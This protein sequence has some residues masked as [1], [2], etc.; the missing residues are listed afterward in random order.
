MDF[1][2][3]SCLLLLVSLGW[4]VGGGFG[5]SSASAS[6]GDYVQIGSGRTSP[7]VVTAGSGRSLP[8]S[9]RAVVPVSNSVN[10]QLW[11]GLPAFLVGDLV[12]S[13]PWEQELAGGG[14]PA[15]GGSKSCDG[16]SC[17]GAIPQSPLSTPVETNH[18]HRELLVV[19]ASDLDRDFRSGMVLGDFEVAV[20]TL[21]EGRWERPPRA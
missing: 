13:R 18:N 7:L 3:I 21:H 20:A 1:S 16:P 14:L 17:R 15:G 8:L 4:G 9:D 19:T 10:R 5:L 2:R 12:G 6:C 11:L